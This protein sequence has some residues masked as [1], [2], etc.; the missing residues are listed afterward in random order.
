MPTRPARSWLASPMS[1]LSV[2]LSQW[3]HGLIVLVLAPSKSPSNVKVRGWRRVLAATKK[4]AVLHPHPKPVTQVQS[5]PSRRWPAEVNGTDWRTDHRAP[6][7]AQA[8]L[9][10]KRN[11][12]TQNPHQ[13]NA[14]AQAQNQHDSYSSQ[15]VCQLPRR[16]LVQAAMTTVTAVT[17]RL[18]SAY[19][20]TTMLQTIGDGPTDCG[21]ILPKSLRT[22]SS[23]HV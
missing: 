11:T 6:S 9:K 8:R 5:C 16:C 20:Y 22:R 13:P 2:S 1:L 21:M 3:G 15:T 18:V 12:R 4:M 23:K 19:Y 10:G 17:S 7:P 14:P